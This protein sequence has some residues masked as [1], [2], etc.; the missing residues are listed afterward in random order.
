M[1]ADSSSST[2]TRD[3]GSQT[4]RAFAILDIVIEEGRPINLTAMAERSD[5]PKPTLHRITSRLEAEGYLIREPGGR[6]YGTSPRLNALA[7]HAPIPRM[8]IEDCH[9]HLPAMRDAAARLSTAL[10]EECKV[11]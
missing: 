8:T 10:F 1:E 4:Q 5:L 7:I 6:N 2:E 11:C 3:K 9:H